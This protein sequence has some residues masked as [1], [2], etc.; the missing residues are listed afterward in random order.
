MEAIVGGIE[1]EDGIITA[2][3]VGYTDAKGQIVGWH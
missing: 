3:S 2:D 1:L